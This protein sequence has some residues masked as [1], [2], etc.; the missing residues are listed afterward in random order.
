MLI[1]NSI[2]CLDSNPEAFARVRADRS[3]VPTALEETLRTLTIT[4]AVTRR[5]TTEVE[6]G[7]CTIPPEQMIIA[8]PG[9]ANRDP[10]KFV[11]PEVFDPARD[12][13]PHLGFG[14]GVH[15]CL[16]AGLARL[17]ARVA[18]NTLLDRFPVL[19]TDPGDPPR[20][21]PTPDIVGTASL[22]LRTR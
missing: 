12:P 5:S 22:P 7:G 17:G 15:Y 21:F 1:G 3:L 2:L 18:L 16:G 13:N 6:I 14:H 11:D 20:F 8:W 4:A 19:S 10:R 9:A